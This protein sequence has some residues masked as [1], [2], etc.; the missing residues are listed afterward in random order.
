MEQLSTED[1]HGGSRGWGLP[2]E[3]GKIRNAENQGDKK[4]GLENLEKS[5]N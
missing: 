3:I 2:G 1:S 4:L 5:L